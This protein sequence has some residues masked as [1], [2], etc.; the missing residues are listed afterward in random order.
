[1]CQAAP[2]SFPA[3]VRLAAV[4]ARFSSDIY[5]QSMA[6]VLE[7]AC[8]ISSVFK[9]ESGMRIPRF[10]TGKRFFLDITDHSGI[11]ADSWRKH[12]NYYVGGVRGVALGT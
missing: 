10:S 2:V 4:D 7:V 11:S 1:M 12:F 8:H 6:P 9:P 3:H 5:R